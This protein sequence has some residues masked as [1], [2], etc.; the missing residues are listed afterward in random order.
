MAKWENDGCFRAL[1]G[2]LV[3]DEV[4]TELMCSVPPISN[5][6]HT[7][8]HVAQVGEAASSICYGDGSYIA[9]YAA[10]AYKGNG[11]WVFLGDIPAIM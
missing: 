10:F 6:H 4:V 2:Q 3:N 8:G 5:A 11:M 9:T 1:T 7:I